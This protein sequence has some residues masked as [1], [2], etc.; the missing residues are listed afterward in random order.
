L[1]GR[2]GYLEYPIIT[3]FTLTIGKLR[4]TDPV[5]LPLT[6]P[7]TRS[8]TQAHNILVS[9]PGFDMADQRFDRIEK[10][11]KELGPILKERIT[12]RMEEMLTALAIKLL[13]MM[14]FLWITVTHKLIFISEFQYYAIKP[15]SES[16]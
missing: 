1:L 10:E 16:L 15:Y 2:Q 5:A 6:K 13:Y 7:I 8:Q 14:P 9:E 4:K 12:K 3:P 11:L